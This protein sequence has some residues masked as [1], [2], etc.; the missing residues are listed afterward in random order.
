MV[1]AER[2]NGNILR[3]MFILFGR[4][5]GGW[6]QGEDVQMWGCGDVRMVAFS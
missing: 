4:R 5:G 2:R 1:A 6:Y 3:R